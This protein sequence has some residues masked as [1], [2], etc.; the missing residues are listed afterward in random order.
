MIAIQLLSFILPISCSKLFGVSRGLND[1][2]PSCI[3]LIKIG[4]NPVE[5]V[6]ETLGLYIIVRG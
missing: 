6:M 5:S 2:G 3:L 4:T 1:P